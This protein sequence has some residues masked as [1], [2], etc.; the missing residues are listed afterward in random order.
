MQIK[1]AGV[2]ELIRGD[3]ISS[4]LSCSNTKIALRYVKFWHRLDFFHTKQK[5]F[6][7]DSGG[8][9]LLAISL[10]LL[11]L[12]LKPYAFCW[13]FHTVTHY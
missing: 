1:N 13:E 9:W 3:F 5:N 6:H 7:L 12:C 2:Q 8:L 11:A 4:L 10:K